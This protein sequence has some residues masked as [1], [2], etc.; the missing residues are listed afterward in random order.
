M[1]Q[2]CG[3][4]CKDPALSFRLAAKE[5]TN[6]KDKYCHRHTKGGWKW[7]RCILQ[8]YNQGPRYTKIERCNGRGWRCRVRARYW[9]R[10]LCFARGIKLM[11]RPR[12]NCR[13]AVS[14]RWIEKAYK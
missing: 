11:R 1:N 3:R 6:Y 7:W 9:L 13:K 10:V 8:I 5:L 2:L 12:W 4:I 14:L